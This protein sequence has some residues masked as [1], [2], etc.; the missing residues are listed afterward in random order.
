MSNPANP[1]EAVLLPALSRLGVPVFIFGAVFL[2]LAFVLTILVSPDRFPVRVGDKIV[3]LSE[4]QAEESELKRRQGDLLAVREK[5]LANSDAPVL[6][7]AQL[8]RGG[9]ND[10]GAV[11]LELERVRKSFTVG[12]NDPVSLPRIEFDAEKNM[13]LLGGSVTDPNRRSI[14]ILAAFVDALRRIPGLERV[15]EP[16]YAETDGPGGSSV[17]P[18]AITLTLQ[19][20]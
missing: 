2:V 19:H 10:P 8:I 11:L 17:T 9:F 4:L 12:D 14:Q 7:Q 1:G 13:F 3:R 6:R 20:E 15:S 5:L 18:F 16:D